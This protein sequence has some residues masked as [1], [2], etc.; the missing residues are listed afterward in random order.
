MITTAL[1]L[2]TMVGFAFTTDPAKAKEFY[3]NFLGFRLLTDDSFALAFDANGSLL[4]VAK[5]QK[6]TPAPHT[7]VGWEVPD[8]QA[9]VQALAQK[10]IQFERFPGLQYDADGICT[11]PGGDKVAWFKDPE[12]SVLSLSQHVIS[13]GSR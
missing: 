11:F 8:I 12:G 4:R 5:A 10:G 7:I 2:K 1:E 9:A 13:V 6:F 3:G